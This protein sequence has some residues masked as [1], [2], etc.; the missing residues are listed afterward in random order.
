MERI[1][2]NG[3]DNLINKLRAHGGLNAKNALALY[4]VACLLVKKQDDQFI[5][6]VLVDLNFSHGTV[7]KVLKEEREDITKTGEDE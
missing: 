1:M 4:K 3:N 6:R 7:A 2:N 5:G